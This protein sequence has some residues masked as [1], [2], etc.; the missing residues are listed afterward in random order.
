MAR[1]HRGLA[2]RRRCR[3]RRQ[4]R[5]GQHRRRPRRSRRPATRSPTPPCGRPSTRTTSRRA[6]LASQIVH[7]SR[8]DEAAVVDD[9]SPARTG[10]RPGRAGGS[11][12]ARNSR[13][14]PGPP[15]RARWRRCPSGSS[16]E[17]GS[18]S[19][20]SSGSWTSAAAQ[21]H[22]LLVSVRE[23]LDLAGW[24][25]RRCRGVRATCGVAAAASSGLMP[26]RRPRY[27]TWSPTSMPGYRP[28]SSGM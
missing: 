14:A 7:R 26:C 1:G 25:D 16:P 9:R 17:S 13:R 3:P 18:S 22:A 15:G 27:S 8:N 6:P 12:R 4:A 23:G 21:L 28:R 20:S 19:T 5:A 10:P 11:R 24:P 2:A